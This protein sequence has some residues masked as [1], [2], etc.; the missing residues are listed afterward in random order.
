MNEIAF[1]SIDTFLAACKNLVLA[2]SN[3]SVTHLTDGSYLITTQNSQV[4]QLLE[5]EGFDGSTY[6]ERI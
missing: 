6:F 1:Y 4:G 3:F 2:Q 5:A